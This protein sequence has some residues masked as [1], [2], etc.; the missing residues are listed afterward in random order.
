MKNGD[1]IEHSYGKGSFIV[2]LK[3]VMFRSYVCIPEG[4]RG[5]LGLKPLSEI[6][7]GVIKHGWLEA[8]DRRN[9]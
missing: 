6:A 8:M 9:Q 2:D 3:M 7:S 1:F 4:S 5:N